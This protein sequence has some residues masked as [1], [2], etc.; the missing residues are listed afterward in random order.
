MLVLLGFFI[1]EVFTE[2]LLAAAG[3]FPGCVL[4]LSAL[5]MAITVLLSHQLQF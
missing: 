3:Q 4:Q 5:A 2:K 1:P